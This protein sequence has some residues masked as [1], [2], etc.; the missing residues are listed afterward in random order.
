MKRDISVPPTDITGSKWATF[1]AGP[2]YSSRTKTKRSVAFD[3]PTEISRILSWMESALHER[4]QEY[5]AS[6]RLLFNER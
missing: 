3:V 5:T 4:C 6:K 2:E 1:K